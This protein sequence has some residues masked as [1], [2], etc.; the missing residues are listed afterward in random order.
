MDIPNP[1]RI[2][3]LLVYDKPIYE[4]IYMRLL[5]KGDDLFNIYG[6]K[7]ITDAIQL[8]SDQSFRDS[9]GCIIVHKDIPGLEN[10]FHYLIT[11]HY[12]EM[13]N[14]RRIIASG[15]V[16]WSGLI[17]NRCRQ[18]VSE[19]L[20]VDAAWNPVNT[21]GM[22]IIPDWLIS[23]LSLGRLSDTEISQCRGN[24]D[25]LVVNSTTSD[26]RIALVKEYQKGIERE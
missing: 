5:E 8:L 20:E 4:A 25:M 18:Y 14:I 13:N 10:I 6:S 24:P 3:V 19:T 26:I 22:E 21:P 16:D 12:G 1:I 23:Q 15:E 11:E 2:N 7:S 9:L 17:D